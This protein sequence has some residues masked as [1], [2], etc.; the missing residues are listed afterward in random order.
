MHH[1]NVIKIADFYVSTSITAMA[2]VIY[3]LSSM[4]AEQFDKSQFIT[5]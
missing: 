3:L 4:I 1:E 2:H 5:K